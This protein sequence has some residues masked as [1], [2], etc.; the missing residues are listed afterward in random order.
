MRPHAR[1]ACDAAPKTYLGLDFYT[2]SD[3]YAVR[4]VQLCGPAAKCGR[5]ALGDRVVSMNGVRVVHAQT[6]SALIAKASRTDNSVTFEI[7]H[8]FADGEGL[9]YGKEHVAIHAERDG[10]RTSLS[11][12]LYA[13]GD[14]DGEGGTAAPTR[15]P[16]RSFSFG[17]RPKF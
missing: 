14:G 12:D 1:R 11:A 2:F 13:D 17:K 4:I 16:K 15:K 10:A 7:A 9:W 8:G 5:L 6:L 3:D